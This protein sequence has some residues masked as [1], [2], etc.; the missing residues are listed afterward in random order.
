MYKNFHVLFIFLTTALIFATTLF[1]PFL[2]S[3]FRFILTWKLFGLTVI[4][5][6]KCSCFQSTLLV[7]NFY[8]TVYAPD[9]SVSVSNIL[10]SKKFFVVDVLFV[11]IIICHQMVF[12]P[13][14]QF[15]FV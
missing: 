12:F 3:R 13:S 15:S 6:S 2:F 1:F 11:H 10:I 9:L 4:G 5:T 14:Q 8:C 7:L